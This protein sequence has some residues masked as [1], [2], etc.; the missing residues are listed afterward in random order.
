MAAWCDVAGSFHQGALPWSQFVGIPAAGSAK[1]HFRMVGLARAGFVLA[2]MVSP[3]DV[4]QA[5]Q[6]P[7]VPSP[8]DGMMKGT[9]EEEAACAPDS[10]KYCS[11]FEPDPLQVLGCLQQNRQRISKACQSV[12]R[13]RGV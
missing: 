4:V 8:F 11:R 13:A 1:G 10:A 2:L 7:R 3:L 9:P 6:Q 5:Q 12:L